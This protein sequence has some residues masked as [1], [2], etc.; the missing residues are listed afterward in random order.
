MAC[1]T[2]CLLILASCNKTPEEL[3]YKLDVDQKALTF[4]AET[5]EIQTITVMA[6]NVEW[7]SEKN[8]AEDTWLHIEKK[9]GTV[10]VKVDDNP[11]TEKREAKFKITPS[12]DSVSTVEITVTQLAKDKE[13]SLGADPVI[14]IFEA[15]ESEMKAI[16]VTSENIEWGLEAM[17][18]SPWLHFEKSGDNVLVR[19]DK[20]LAPDTREGKFKIT[21]D[22][23]SV[24]SI[25]IAVTQRANED[26]DI[27]ISTLAGY[28][29]D[30]YDNGESNFLLSLYTTEIDSWGIPQETGYQ[31][32]FDFFSE[33][34]SSEARPDIAT[35]IYHIENTYKKYTAIPGEYYYDEYY[36]EGYNYSRVAYFR[37][38]MA[39]EQKGISSGTFTV[40]RSGSEY[41]ITADLI[42]SDETALKVYFKGELPVANPFLSTLTEDTQIAD[43][44]GARVDFHGDYYDAGSY[45]WCI[46]MWGEG[47][48][49]NGGPLIGSGDRFNLDFFSVKE[50]EGTVI[51]AGNYEIL[52]NTKAAG[53]AIPG[54]VGFTY[55][56]S[57]YIALENNFPSGKEAPLA[58]EYIRI[59]RNGDVYVIEIDARDDAGNKIT[60]KYEGELSINNLA[61]AG[62]QQP[63]GYKYTGPVRR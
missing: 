19:V 27:I 29:Q 22:I 62:P 40:D 50:G 26:V 57:W 12:V 5:N 21:S 9:D 28:R 16:S 43:M 60:C 8:N 56:G 17:G 13:Y 51:P 1:L 45:Y 10:L 4:A 48:E 20:N 61:M 59:T 30:Y 54:Y 58:S 49:Y 33:F 6:E 52:P 63:Q 47:L 23:G 46:E 53:T 18:E 41:I 34:P 11:D 31:I 24:S 7:G 55:L 15:E 36:G 44:K 3:T 37:D 38:G 39:Y 42:L 35:G 32:E 2:G 14:L 25:E